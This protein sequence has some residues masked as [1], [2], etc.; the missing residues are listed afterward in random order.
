MP[1]SLDKAGYSWE[2]T[3]FFMLFDQTD[4]AT[5]SLGKVCIMDQWFDKGKYGREC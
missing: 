4:D 1:F 5:N 2:Q 3:K